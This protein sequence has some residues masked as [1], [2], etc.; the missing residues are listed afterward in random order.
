[1]LQDYKPS[2]VPTR[3]QIAQPIEGT[4]PSLKPDAAKLYEQRIVA[5]ERGDV[6]VTPS[7]KYLTNAHA[8]GDESRQC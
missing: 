1:M 5:T 3:Q 4:P 8:A 2:W 6:S 7:T